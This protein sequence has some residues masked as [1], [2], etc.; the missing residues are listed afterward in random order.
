MFLLYGVWCFNFDLGFFIVI[1]IY[2]VY[3]KIEMWVFYICIDLGVGNSEGMYGGGLCLGWLCKF[4][5]KC[6]EFL[7]LV[8]WM[9]GIFFVLFFF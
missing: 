1:C 5:L 3:L 4:C 2:R 6:L 7:G 9:R 8:F